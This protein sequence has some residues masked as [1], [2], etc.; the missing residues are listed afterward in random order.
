MS[1]CE[2]GVVLSAEGAGA[3]LK[4]IVQVYQ[5]Y[6]WKVA[7]DQCDAIAIA[8]YALRMMPASRLLLHHYSRPEKF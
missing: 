3:E 1:R 6:V 7:V 4:S 8:V 5:R 2:G